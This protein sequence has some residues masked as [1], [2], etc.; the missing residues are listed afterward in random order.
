MSSPSL[1]ARRSAFADYL[2]LTKPRI[3]LLVVHDARGS[4]YAPR[5]T[6]AR[7]PPRCSAPG[8]A[9]GAA[10]STL[11]SAAPAR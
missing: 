6:A 8:S 7:H 11:S 2:D 4:P 10:R 1:A 5:E 9:A 3:T